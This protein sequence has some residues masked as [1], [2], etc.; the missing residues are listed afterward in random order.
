MR[1]FTL[2]AAMA[3]LGL[4]ACSQDEA[5]MCISVQSLGGSPDTPEVRVTWKR[6]PADHTVVLDST[7]RTIDEFETGTSGTFSIDFTLLLDGAGTTTTGTVALPLRGDWR[8][9]VDLILSEEDPTATCFGPGD[10]LPGHDEA[11]G[12]VG[13]ELDQQSGGLLTAGW[14]WPDR[15]S[16]ACPGWRS[17]PMAL[18]SAWNCSLKRP[19]TRSHSWK[20]DGSTIL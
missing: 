19:Q 15:Q 5:R 7:R 18:R 17:K 11:V 4:L 13:R 8:W 6:W 9:G 12:G 20:I 1:G 3:T 10:G 14:C 16:A 2:I